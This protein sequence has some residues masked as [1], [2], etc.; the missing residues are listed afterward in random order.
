MLAAFEHEL[1]RVKQHEK[2]CAVISEV[3]QAAGS[4]RHNTARNAMT[5][6]LKDS[7]REQESWV[8]SHG[9]VVRAA[10]KKSER[11]GPVSL[12]LRHCL[13]ANRPCY[14][15]P[16]ACCARS[17]RHANA[18][19]VGRC[20]CAHMPPRRCP[21]EMVSLP[22][23]QDV[24]N[25]AA[26][27]RECDRRAGLVSAM[28]QRRAEDAEEQ[29]AA[30]ARELRG[31]ARGGLAGRPPH[32]LLASAQERIGRQQDDVQGLYAELLARR[33]ALLAAS[34][35]R[36]QMSLANPFAPNAHLI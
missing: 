20:R 23:M 7:L 17:H 33:D 10:A 36:G 25:M 18:A 19:P 3:V 31:V 28:L 32:P 29:A 34:E 30:D 4:V 15:C 21:F 2:V 9:L 24:A 35:V 13:V 1:Q 5:Q 14:S 12:S 11:S 26:D 8:R 6:T 16:Q 22:L 27:L